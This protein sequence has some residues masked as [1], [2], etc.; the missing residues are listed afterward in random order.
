VWHCPSSE[1][2]LGK[3]YQVGRYT[4]SISVEGSQDPLFIYLPLSFHHSAFL[5]NSLRPSPGFCLIF[6]DNEDGR[7]SN[8]KVDTFSFPPCPYSSRPLSESL[9]PF[10]FSHGLEKKKKGF[11]VVETPDPRSCICPYFQPLLKYSLT[12]LSCFMFAL[13]A[14][15]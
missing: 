8:E 6:R 12:S 13:E 11:T 14:H 9:R 15:G 10:L 4:P 7:S 5:K 3:D 1:Y 2:F